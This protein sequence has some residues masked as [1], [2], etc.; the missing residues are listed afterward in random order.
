M[1]STSAE[2]A[3]FYQA[4]FVDLKGDR[5]SKDSVNVFIFVM[6]AFVVSIDVR[7]SD[8]YKLL[9]KEQQGRWVRRR[10]RKKAGILTMSGAKIHLNV[11][12][13]HCYLIQEG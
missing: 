12:S 4:V 6:R 5:A 11:F 3:T 1:L 7:I 9:S 8:K 10:D 2:V 13:F